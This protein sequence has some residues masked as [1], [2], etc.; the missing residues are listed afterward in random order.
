[1]DEDRPRALIV[2]DNAAVR[3]LLRDVLGEWGFDVVAVAASGEEGVELAE[4]FRPAVVVM[5]YRMPGID[6]L[7]ATR[8]IREVAPG[9]RVVV[10]SASEGPAMDGA[11]AAAGAFAYVPKGSAGELRRALH[12]AADADLA[13]A[14]GSTRR[15]RGGRRGR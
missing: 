13:G 14:A 10:I 15:V 6:G 9:T 5:D 7:E 11:A 8:R 12:Q 3:S 2:E 4:R 1:M